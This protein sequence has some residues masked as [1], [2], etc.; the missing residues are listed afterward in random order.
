MKSH[1][2]RVRPSI[3]ALAVLACPTIIWTGQARAD[4]WTRVPPQPTACYASQDYVS[5][6][7]DAAYET[8]SADLARAKEAQE[9]ATAQAQ[10]NMGQ[11]DPFKY[12]EAMSQMAMDDPAKMAEMTKGTSA[13]ESQ[14]F[15]EQI[16]ASDQQKK[17]LEDELARLNERYETAISSAKSWVR[18]RGTVEEQ[19]AARRSMTAADVARF[20]ASY[21]ST[22]CP[23]WF[24]SSGE[25]AAWLKRYKNY[26]VQKQI[27]IEKEREAAAVRLRATMGDE[28][29]APPSAA[30]LAAVKEYIDYANRIYHQREFGP[31]QLVGVDIKER[32]LQGQAP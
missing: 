2:N 16:A 26:L 20:Y 3:A 6:K 32:D 14:Q 31:G 7:Y 28:S 21:E 4:D 23:Q 25:Y 5:K 18:P 17:A 13:G 30:T 1:S 24:G 22:I 27:P 9:Q 10:E 19:V 12:M 11:V 29:P 15:A 8:V